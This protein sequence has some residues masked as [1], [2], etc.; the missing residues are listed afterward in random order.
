MSGTDEPTNTGTGSNGTDIDQLLTE[1][2]TLKE[3]VDDPT[4]REQVREAMKVAQNLPRT[5]RAK[6]RI[7]KYTTRDVAEGFVGG[8]LLSLPLLV[9]DGVFE[10]AEWFLETVV[11]GIPLF[12]VANIG[13]IMLMVYG[14]L[15]WSDIRNVKDP[16]PILGVIPRRYVGVLLISLVTAA[17]LLV[18]WGRHVEEDPA[19]T[20]EVFGR[21]TVIWAAAA[22]GAALGDIL[23]GESRGHDVVLENINEIVTKE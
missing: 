8:I 18:L 4:E 11:F 23:P 9:E 7:K 12:L 6:R 17:F 21:V 1:L 5:E 2:E 3:T 14:L 20:L 15:Y 10:I 13:F 22:F 16:N 19:S